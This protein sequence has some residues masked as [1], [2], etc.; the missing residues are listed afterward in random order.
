MPV[1]SR[2]S[3]QRFQYPPLRLLAFLGLLSVVAVALLSQA[4]PVPEE[5][6]QAGLPTTE[7]RIGP[8]TY[9]LEVASTPK[10][11]ELGLMYRTVLPQNS[12]MLFRFAETRPVAFWMK[13]TRIPL[14]MLFVKSGKI[15]NI[16]H[17]AQPCHQEPCPVY[18]SGLPVDMVIE[19]P[20]GTALKDQIKAGS[21]IQ[22]TAHTP[23]KPPPTQKNRG[24]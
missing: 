19:L 24:L 20:G 16:A 8:K 2:I 11:T 17:Q 21:L 3:N 4:E 18:P 6:P 5:K 7:L 13:N 12:G 9:L 10:Q 14:D 15:V 1:F 22:L 23:L